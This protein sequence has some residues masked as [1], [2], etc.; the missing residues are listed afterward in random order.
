MSFKSLLEKAKSKA[1]SFAHDRNIPIQT[2]HRSNNGPPPL[3]PNK[4]SYNTPQP[5]SYWHADF[6][7]SIQVSQVFKHQLGD[8][9]WGNNEL[10]NYVAAPENSFHT[11]DG[12]LVLRAIASNGK[13]TSARLTSHQTL[14]KQKGSLVAVVTPPCAPGIWPALWLLPNEPFEWPRETEIDIVQ[15]WNGDGVN[16][17]CLHWGNYNGEDWNKH[18]VIES[19][20]EGLAMRPVRYEFS[21]EQDESKGRNDGGGRAVWSI[22]GRAVMKASIPEGARRMDDWQIIINVAMGGNVCGGTRPAD[23]QYDMVVHELKLCDEPS[24]GWKKF[25][26]DWQMAPEGR[27]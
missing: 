18:R 10:Q 6:S 11:Q 24:G 7:T 27:P 25:E 5:Q 16:H 8:H 13:Y 12:K 22:D 19:R 14:S 4:P 1:E 3:P 21:W 26:Q 2:Q 15:T 20:P 9:G 23:G 17:S